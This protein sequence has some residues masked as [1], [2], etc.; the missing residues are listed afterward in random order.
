MGK[1]NFLHSKYTCTYALFA[2]YIPVFTI[3]M[4]FELIWSLFGNGPTFIEVSGWGLARITNGWWAALLM[5]AN[6]LPHFDPQ[7]VTHGTMVIVSLILE[8]CIRTCNESNFNR[9][10]FIPDSRSSALFNDGS[11]AFCHRSRGLLSFA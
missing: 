6:Y 8:L 4:L 7:G 1:V 9:Y 10:L 3:L 2:R 5:L 11:A